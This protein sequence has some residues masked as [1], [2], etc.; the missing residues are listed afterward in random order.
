MRLPLDLPAPSIVRQAEGRI[1]GPDHKPVAGALVSVIDQRSYRGVGFSISDRDGRFSVGLLSTPVVVTATAN[2]YV[3]ASLAPAAGPLSFTL[4][5]SSEATRRISG[6][7]VGAKGQP[8][9]QVRVRLMSWSWPVGAAFYTATDNGGRFQFSVDPAGS[10][11]VMVDDPRLVSNF[12]PLQHRDVDNVQLIAYERDWIATQASPVDESALR[13]LCVPLAGDGI[14]QFA[15]SL[16]SALVVG[17]GE[18]THGT[19]EFTELRNVS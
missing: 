5:R 7:V 13:E 3:A 15:G 6:A 14:H 4:A 19:R 18:S 8:L 12:A 16:R 10:Y 17:L 2:G 9:A 11:D 1:I